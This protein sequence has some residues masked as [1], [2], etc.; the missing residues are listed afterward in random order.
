MKKIL[1]LMMVIMLTLIT[2]VV[3]ADE[4]GGAK[5]GRLFLFQKCDA[6]LGGTT[7]NGVNYDSSGCPKADQG[8][9]PII[10][11]NR[12]W[13]K[14]NYN[15][16]GKK[17][18]FSF[19]GKRLEPKINYTLIYYPDDW[20]VEGLICL[21]NGTSNKSGKIKIKGNNDIGTSLPKKDV[22]ENFNPISPS[23]A[24]GAKIWLVK[25]DDVK[26]DSPSCM[27]GWNPTAY[28]FEY[29]LIVYERR[30]IDLDEDLDD[31]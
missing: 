22:D 6:T 4:N 18:N 23:G 12:R 26:C 3:V 24:V 8:P 14:L 5:A 2:S 1:I 10:S 16:W 7:A 11:T 17:F 20:P 28:L 31:D 29:N 9:W 27:L 30:E 13:G 25:S 19:E 15:L 21:G